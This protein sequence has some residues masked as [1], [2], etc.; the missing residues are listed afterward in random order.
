MK[1]KHLYLFAGVFVVLLLIY[2][3]TKPR[4]TSVNLDE[5]VQAIVIGMAKDDVKNIEVYKETTSQKPIQMVFAQREGQW[6]IPTKFN[7]KAQKSRVDRLLDD[8]LEMTGKVRSSDPKHLETYQISDEKG[9]HLLL[10]DEANKPL[11]NLIIGKKGE[12][13]NSGFVRFGGKEKVYAVDKNLLSSLSITGEI[14][15]LSRFKDDSFV[16]LQ[17]VNQDQAK[18]E[19]VGIV[20]RGKELV[21]KKKA[22]QVEITNPD[23]TK[24]TKTE[25]EWVLLK[26]QKET[27]LDQKEVT[28]FL[29]TV[30]KIY[31]QEVVDRM[32][33]TLGDLDKASRYGMTRPVSYLVFKP[34]EKQQENVIFG[35]EYEKDKGFYMQV[36]YDGLVYKVAKSNVDRIFKWV[37]D[38]PK[39]VVK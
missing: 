15:T 5:I 24:G 6:Y 4:H 1:E 13:Y 11:A 32:G 10:K 38:L 25:H 35:K 20:D 34:Q 17:A 33:N 18:L 22:K 27:R 23:S 8:V 19:I 21:I 9:I 36:Q 12:D 3:V 37:E 39:K 2:F 26:G 28:S 16:D 31:A 14:D 30:T 7:S 29:N